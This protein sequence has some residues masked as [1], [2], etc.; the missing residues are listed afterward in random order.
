MYDAL[1][2]LTQLDEATWPFFTNALTEYKLSKGD[3]ILHPGQI[4]RHIFFI[5]TGLLRSFY[6][7]D[8][9]ECS[10]AFTAENSFITDL[11]SLRSEHPTKMTIQALEPSVI[12]SISKFELISLYRESHQLETFGR[13]LLESLL[14][15]QEEYASWF[16]LYSAKE[17]YALFCQRHPSLVRRLSLSHLASFLGI[18]RETLSRIR[19][20][21]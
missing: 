16:K 15:E 14:E 4:C 10:V 9:D 1:R 19:R 13:S 21:R 17:R 11:K 20:L 6:I 3:T 7:N 5:Q 2:R 18:R 12:L 8:G